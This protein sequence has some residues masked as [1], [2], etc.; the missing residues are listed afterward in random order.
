MY[1]HKRAFRYLGT[2]FHCTCKQCI[3]KTYHIYFQFPPSDKQ[4]E[5]REQ[6]L[7]VK[8]DNTVDRLTMKDKNPLQDHSQPAKHK[9]WLKLQH[10]HKSPGCEKHNGDRL[11]KMMP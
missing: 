7:K 6:E 8:D 3:K 5:F 10:R 11:I 2:D 9:K 4:W 1:Y